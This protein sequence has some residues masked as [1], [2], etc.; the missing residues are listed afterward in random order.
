MKILIAHNRYIEP[1]G[2]D[3][4]FEQEVSL[5]RRFGH[6]VLTYER[7]NGEL[8]EMKLIPRV[9]RSAEAVWS[10][11]TYSEFSNLLTIFMPD[12]VHVHNT[13]L[14]IS[15]SIFQACADKGIPVVNTI[16]N[17]RL[18]C[19]A[20]TLYRDG[21]PCEKCVGGNMWQGIARGCYRSSRTATALSASVTGYN[22]L[23]RT[24]SDAVNHY[25]APT[26]FV[27]D[28]MADAGLP[29]ARIS[30]KPHFVDPDPCV[31]A[32]PES[33]ALFLGRL[34][35]EKGVTTL[36]SAWQQLSDVPLLIVGDGPQRAEMERISHQRNLNCRF[37]GHRTRTD[38]LAKLKKARLLVFPSIGYETFGMGIIEA[39]ACGVPVLASNHG[40]MRELVQTGRTGLLFEPA[41]PD[42]LAHAVRR[43]WSDDQLRSH[44]SLNARREY[45]NKY[46][47]ATNY[48][49]LMSIY[50][51]VLSSGKAS[52]E[53]SLPTAA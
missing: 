16:H 21:A 25:I 18:L 12:I 10:S 4:V 9:L 39:Y 13:F 46:T 44:M 30:V 32:H 48:E 26:N 45:E 14:R 31:A 15:P 11:T 20:T 38:V 2:E 29:A 41:N 35:P 42:A 1:G 3:V 7:G 6:D 23:R 51:R 8:R 36:L 49:M 40:A 52:P 24:W 17:Y 27:R 53:A 43:C 5:L 28:K 22:W 34:S 19:P 37:E 50:E 33:Y 47:A